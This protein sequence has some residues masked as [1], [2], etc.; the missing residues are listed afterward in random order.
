LATR[1]RGRKNQGERRTNKL[2]SG[3]PDTLP[4]GALA[5]VAGGAVVV[6]AAAEERVRVATLEDSAVEAS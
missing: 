3:F 4:V 5:D 1:A 6:A 2:A